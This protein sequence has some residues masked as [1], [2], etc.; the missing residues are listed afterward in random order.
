M[1][2]ECGKSL[3]PVYD[4][5]VRLISDL[6]DEFVNFFGLLAFFAFEVQGHTNDNKSDIFISNNFTDFTDRAAPVFDCGKRLCYDLERVA[7]G[8]SNAGGSKI[9]SHNP[10]L[11]FEG[12]VHN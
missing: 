6:I 2:N 1:G 3:I 12:L 4:F 5:H 8:Y 10:F 9:K 7:K 11:L